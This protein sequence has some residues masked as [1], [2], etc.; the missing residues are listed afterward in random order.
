MVQLHGPWCKPALVRKS[1]QED[2]RARELGLHHKAGYGENWRFRVAIIPI[3]R[4]PIT[5]L[6]PNYSGVNSVADMDFYYYSLID[7]LENKPNIVL[8]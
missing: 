1:S 4:D 2:F 5:T 3:A 6:T 8:Q 7:L